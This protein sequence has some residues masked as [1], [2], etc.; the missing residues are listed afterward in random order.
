MHTPLRNDSR[1][2]ARLLFSC[3]AALA[4]ALT[5]CTPTSTGTQS[6]KADSECSSG[7]VCN[8]SLCKKTCSK[9]TDC[10]VGQDCRLATATDTK[11]TCNSI[12]YTK[13]AS[14]GFG[15]DC[16]LSACGTGSSPCAA[17]FSCKAQEKCDPNAYC[18]ASC[19]NDLD[20]PS[21][22]FCSAFPDA[23]VTTGTDCSAA[24]STCPDGSFCAKSKD[25]NG[26]DIRICEQKSCVP[27][28][29]CDPCGTDEQCRWNGLQQDYICAADNIGGK[30]CGPSCIDDSDC[31]KPFK[32]QASNGSYITYKRFDV[33][34]NGACTPTTGACHGKSAIE[35]VS[36]DNQICSPCR[37]GFDEDCGKTPD[38]Q[39]LY[40]LTPQSGETLCAPL[41]TIGVTAVPGQQGAYQAVAGTDTCPDGF[42]CL[43]SVP[44]NC[45][46]ACNA[47]GLC[48]HDPNG[49]GYTCTAP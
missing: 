47:S 18:S 31:L 19:K 40:C 21:N 35:T 7:Q 30:F 29:K 24:G 6:C 45:G 26:V 25:E 1:S 16:S 22:F 37:P 17:G 10:T 13:P 38:G 46:S 12:H 39:K 28:V 14:G 43:G 27:R 49:Q 44:S 15:T 34:L 42:N 8:Q 9:T 41:C 4:L 11:P 3:A 32:A 2:S 48:S 23:T 33:C 5:G 36:G 20:C